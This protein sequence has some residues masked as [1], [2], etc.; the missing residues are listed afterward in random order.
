MSLYAFDGTWNAD[1][2]HDERDTNVRKFFELS[3]EPGHRKLYTP[4]VGTRYGLIGSIAGGMFGAGSFS[5]VKAAY[6]H[7]CERHTP[8][9]P[10]DVIGFSRGAALALDFVNRVVDSAAQ[11]GA[12]PPTF[13]FIGLFDVVGSFGLPFNLGPIPTHNIN[14]GHKLSLPPAQATQCFHALALDECRQTFVVTR[15]AG[16]H[17]V[18]FRGVHSDIGGGNGNTKLS[19]IALR[20]MLRRAIAA[21]V[22][23]DQV[24]MANLRLD[25]S[26]DPSAAM[27]LPKDFVRNAF[28]RARP[29]IACTTRLDRSRRGSIATRAIPLPSITLRPSSMSS[30]HAA[31][32]PSERNHAEEHRH[33]LGRNREQQHRRPWHERL[34][35]V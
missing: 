8:G 23:I 3:A 26:I 24:R 6:K 16:A 12:P 14:L 22:P 29:A 33:L 9:E 5:R 35:T 27:K 28:R 10:I 15:V 13:R 32:L 30:R 11:P 1:K 25:A 19:Y 4:G 21:G 34:Q 18:W 2:E 17:E 7:L 31:P 20:W